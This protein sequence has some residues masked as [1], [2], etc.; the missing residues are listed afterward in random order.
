MIEF[1][2]PPD[3]CLIVNAFSQ[4]ST[5][6]GAAQLLN[7][8]PAGL[9][10]KVQR[11]SAEYGFLQKVGNRWAVTESGRRVAQWTD[12]IIHSQRKLRD[13]R[14]R[15]RI[16]A[17]TWL[18]EEMLIPEFGRLDSAFE[19]KYSWSFKMVASDLEQELIQSRSDFVIT[20][21]APKDPAVAHKRITTYPWVV[22]IP[23]SWKKLVTG[24][25]GAD[26]TEFLQT[27]PFVWHSAT[28]PEQIL[29]FRPK[30]S[31]GLAVDGVIGLRSAVVNGLGWSALPA[32]SV[33]SF[34]SENK[35]HQLELRTHIKDEVSI[36]WLRARRDAAQLAK[37]ISKWVSEFNV[38]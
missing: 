10:R 14:P 25:S 26:L 19:S 18:A 22:V 24:L 27:Q 33:K 31:C 6:R 9:V 30:Y 32:M 4:A 38:R 2:I 7:T 17:F 16:A 13:E 3:Y 23:Y 37:P 35:L 36:W 5:L 28:N 12:E 21:H 11:I 34:I 1:P 29:D 15:L 20:G 8:D